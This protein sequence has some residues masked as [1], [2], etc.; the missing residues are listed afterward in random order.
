M[1]STGK[2]MRIIASSSVHL[3]QFTAIAEDVSSITSLSFVGFG[4]LADGIFGA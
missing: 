4:G 3:E 1:D 2:A